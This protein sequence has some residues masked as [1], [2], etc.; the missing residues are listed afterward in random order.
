M[1]NTKV[2]YIAILSIILLNILPTKPLK[3]Y[4]TVNFI[5]ESNDYSYNILV[6][7]TE[8]KLYLINKET[9]NAVK[10][11]PVATGKSSTPSPIGTWTVVSKASEW[12]EGFGTRWLGLN[13]PWG[14]Y[15]IHGTNKPHSI[16]GAASHGCIR[17]FNKDI[18]DLYKL[19]GYGTTVVIYGG[20]YGFSSNKFRT[21]I[22]GDRGSDILEIQRRMQQEGY[23]PGKL[24]GIYGDGMKSY[25]IKFRRD[26][27]LPISHNIDKCFR[28]ALNIKL[29]E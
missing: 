7:L 11:Y 18:E 12:G 22:P 10:S 2:L 28:D 20:P 15:G 26:R 16:G 21:L 17:M 27:K 3:A 14:K 9:N 24:D 1:K 6:D 5:H 13:V 23:Y 29:F 25:V 8:Q 4:A 19:V